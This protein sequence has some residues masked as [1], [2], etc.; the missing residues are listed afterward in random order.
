MKKGWNYALIIFLAIIFL[1]AIVYVVTGI[2]T[3][4]YNYEDIII[5]L[6]LIISSRFL[7]SLIQKLFKNKN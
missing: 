7:P 4:H 5:I 1:Y 6:F 2:F 3:R